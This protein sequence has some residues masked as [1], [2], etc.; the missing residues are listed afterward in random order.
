MLQIS[1]TPAGSLAGASRDSFA[2]LSLSLPTLDQYRAQFP[3]LVA[4]CGPDWL[5]ILA[6]AAMDGGRS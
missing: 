3:I 2:G 1:E 6:A 5:A 4:H